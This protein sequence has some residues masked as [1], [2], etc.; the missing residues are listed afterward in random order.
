VSNLFLVTPAAERTSIHSRENRMRVI[1]FTSPAQ[2]HRYADHWNSLWQR[3]E[4]TVSTVRAELLAQWVERFAPQRRFQ[5]LVVEQQ[6]RFLA[7]LPLVDRSLG[8]VLDVGGL[9]S[10]EWTHGGDLLLDPSENGGEALDALVQ[11]L[12]CL[13]WKLLCLDAVALE[14]TRWQ[15][16]T[17]AV[18]RAGGSSQSNKRFAVAMVPLQEDWP[19]YRGTLSA[20]H[21]HKMEKQLRRLRLEGPAELDV[22]A[23]FTADRARELI[24]QGFD[25]EDRSWKGTTAT[26][27]MKSPGMLDFYVRQ[28]QQLAQCGHLRISRLQ[29]NRRTIAFQYG[30]AAKG[31]YHAY[32]I[33]YD[34]TFARFSPGQL[35]FYLLIKHFHENTEVRAINGM[36]PVDTATSKWGPQTFPVGRLVVAS[37]QRSSR[38]LLGTYRHAARLLG[39]TKT[40]NGDR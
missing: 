39:R 40:G 22:T 12:T 4:V 7:A 15:M 10:N 2:L 33:G 21:R 29:H 26:S 17:D 13:P 11:S 5:A 32:K 3:S 37:Q 20:G 18:R 25:V 27:V 24:E 28:S 34:P 1:E 35:L 36:G 16:F 9:P 19:S 8:G 14:S 30:W 6:G 38:F 23:D 31:V